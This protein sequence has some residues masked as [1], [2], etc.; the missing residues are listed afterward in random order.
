MVVANYLVSIYVGI[1]EG[2][3]KEKAYGWRRRWPASCPHHSGGWRAACNVSA[4][5]E[6]SG[7]VHI[8]AWKVAG[9]GIGGA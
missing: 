6:G 5:G 3:A 4:A 1:E 2:K 9:K 7:S 8:M